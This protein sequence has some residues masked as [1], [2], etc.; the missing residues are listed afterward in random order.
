VSRQKGKWVAQDGGAKIHKVRI[1]DI[2]FY[3]FGWRVAAAGKTE[4]LIPE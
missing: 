1:A 4:W 3:G 2:W